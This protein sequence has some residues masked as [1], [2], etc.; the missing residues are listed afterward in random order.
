MVINNLLL[1]LRERDKKSILNAKNA[2]LSLKGEIDELIDLQVEVDIR[3]GESSY[4]IILITKF[5]CMEDLDAYIVHPKHIEVA[6]YIGGIVDTQA[7]VC[8]E[9]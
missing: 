8:Y 3:H 7:A 6:K 1:K 2:L 5:A 9:L 4:D